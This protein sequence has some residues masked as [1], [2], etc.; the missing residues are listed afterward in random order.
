[1]RPDGPHRSR[2]PRSA[3]KNA[4][5]KNAA[6]PDADRTAVLASVR[7]KRETAK[8]PCL[9][10]SDP[11]IPP[12]QGCALDLEDDVSGFLDGMF[13]YR[14]NERAIQDCLDHAVL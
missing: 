10:R 3:S 9:L 5:I 14:R 12:V 7:G 13:G 1:M 11:D 8:P 6:R 2:T 4:S